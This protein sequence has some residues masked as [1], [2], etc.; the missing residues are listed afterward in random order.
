MGNVIKNIEGFMMNLGKNPSGAAAELNACGNRE[1]CFMSIL[2]EEANGDLALDV[3]ANIGYTTLHLCNHMKRVIAIEPDDR[4]RNLLKYNIKL[5]N[6]CDKVSIYSFAISN[7]KDT[8]KIYLNEKPNLSSLVKPNKIIKNKK[9]VETKKIKTRTIDSLGVLPNF[10]KMDIEGY[11]IEA[12]EG[13]MIT[14]SNVK[15]CKILLEVHPQYYH[16]KRNFEKTIRKLLKIG[17]KFK[18]LVS[19]G[20][21]QPLLFKNKGYK[22]ERIVQCNEYERGIYSN[23]S[24]ED[25]INFSCHSHIEYVPSVKKNTE[26]IVR[27]ILLVK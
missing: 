26:K 4:T 25:A 9:F 24:E 16:K 14:L 1:P 21:A 7:K 27:S 6:L 18:Y 15:Y 10:I 20:I 3:G 13:A 23:I 12:L 8:V 17:F 19:A 11:E 5:N 2:K 22:P